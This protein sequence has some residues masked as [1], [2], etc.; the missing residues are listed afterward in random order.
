LPF[1]QAWF[2]RLVSVASL[3]GLISLVSSLARHVAEFELD[4]ARLRYRLIGRRKWRELPLDDVS[5]VDD[6]ETRG[7]AVSV[8]QS[9]DGRVILLH[10]PSLDAAGLLAARLKDANRAEHDRLEGSISAAASA[11]RFGNAMLRRM[12]CGASLA[13]GLFF[14]FLGARA[15]LAGLGMNPLP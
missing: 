15:R 12:L 4:A 14:A 6:P 8:I 5:G 11:A 13:I 7:G 2:A 1:P 9:A 3:W 10:H